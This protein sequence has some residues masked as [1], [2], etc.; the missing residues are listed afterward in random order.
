MKVKESKVATREE[1]ARFTK[2]SKKRAKAF[3]T[4]DSDEYARSAKS[5]LERFCK[6]GKI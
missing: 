1:L 6:K 3:G 5:R 4:K 2:E